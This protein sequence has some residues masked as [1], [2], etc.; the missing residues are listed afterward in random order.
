M[1]DNWGLGRVRHGDDQGGG[2][3]SANDST[4]EGYSGI[5]HTCGTHQDVAIPAIKTVIA[6][7]SED[8]QRRRNIEWSR[9]LYRKCIR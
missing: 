4:D 5:C 7:A 9:E 6:G 3:H 2:V 1:L 8:V